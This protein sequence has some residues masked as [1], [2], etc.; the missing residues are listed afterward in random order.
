MCCVPEISQPKKSN[1]S[2]HVFFH[3]KYRLPVWF[4]PF[5]WHTSATNQP[6]FFLL[7]HC[8]MAFA[9]HPRGVAVVF[10]AVFFFHLTNF[11][12]GSIW[13]TSWGWKVFRF[14]ACE[15]SQFPPTTHPP[16]NTPCPVPD[17]GTFRFCW[18]YGL[19]G[20]FNSVLLLQLTFFLLFIVRVKRTNEEE[21]IV[22]MIK[23]NGD[24]T[25]NKQ[26]WLAGK[27]KNKH[28][29]RCISYLKNWWFS[30][31]WRLISNNNQ[32]NKNNDC[33]LAAEPAHIAHNVGGY[34]SMAV[35]DQPTQNVL[36]TSCVFCCFFL[37]FGG[38][39]CNLLYDSKVG[40]G[41]LS[42]LWNTEVLRLTCGHWL[43]A[44]DLL[45]ILG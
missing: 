40:F 7:N 1:T 14:P 38:C 8:M 18:I 42:W 28:K 10:F 9:P 37:W 36:A 4:I 23:K 12:D 17:S 11:K 25:S 21:V 6:R 32:T 24:Y 19:L 30:V 29:W 41:F 15:S 33:T 44:I 34:R 35:R 16:V 20:L 31:Y 22:F 26:R 39:F 2:P 27:W 3:K 13:S 45:S 5:F 43:I